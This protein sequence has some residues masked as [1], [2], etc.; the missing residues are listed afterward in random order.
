MRV[1]TEQSLN[2]RDTLCVVL[3]YGNEQDTLDCLEAITKDDFL[4]VIVVDND[5][6]QQFLLPSGF[7]KFAH[8]VK[9]GG[10]MG[11]AQANN[12]G[13]KTGRHNHHRFVLILNNDTV[14]LPGAMAVLRNALEDPQ[15]GIVGPVMPYFDKPDELWAAGGKISKWLVTIDGIRT[16]PDKEL[17]DVGYLPGAAFLTRLDLWDAIGGLSEKYFLAFEEAEYAMEIAK[18]GY[19]VVVSRDSSILH[20]VGMSSDRQP[21]YFYN[22]VRNRIRFGGHLWG[23]VIGPPLGAMSALVRSCNFRRIRVWIRA[24]LDELKKRPLDKETLEA[25]R[26][27]FADSRA[28]NRGA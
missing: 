2:H 16:L 26:E 25:V 18:R 23:P 10:S 5:P 9:S 21:M 3:H 17:T 1:E 24:V 14:A 22:T 6:R 7:K 28:N 19:R 13:V 11:F 8:V 15:V 4:D 12:F 20:K 27:N